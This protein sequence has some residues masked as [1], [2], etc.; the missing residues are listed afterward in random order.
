MPIDSDILDYLLFHSAN[1]HVPKEILIRF[2]FQ[3]IG[4][5]ILFIGAL[6]LNEIIVL[7]FCGFNTNTYLNILERSKNDSI[8][9]L[10]INNDYNDNDNE[11]ESHMSPSECAD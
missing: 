10:N 2:A 7:N 6:I 5:I 4:Y 9:L 1:D 3:M 11:S 8:I